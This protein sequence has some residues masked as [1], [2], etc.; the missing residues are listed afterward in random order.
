MLNMTKFRAPFNKRPVSGEHWPC[1]DIR[2]GDGIDPRYETTCNRV[3]NRKALQLCSQVL[4]ALN[5][6]F[7]D[8]RGLLADLMVESVMP[9]PDSSQL[10]ITV[11]LPQDVAASEAWI[12]IHAASGWLRSEVASY[13]SRKRTPQL[14]YQFVTRRY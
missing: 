3:P 8:G 6:A 4:N 2:E 9:A 7:A 12:A 5:L 10:L 1:D 14:R 11:S 13:I